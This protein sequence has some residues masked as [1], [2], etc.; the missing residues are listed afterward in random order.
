MTS[1]SDF[2]LDE[3]GKG[4]CDLLYDKL[5]A[6]IGTDASVQG[7]HFAVWAPSARAISVVGDFN[8]WRAGVNPL[9]SRG[10]SGVWSGFV[11]GV[12]Q[13][14]LYK[15]S[16]LPGD[17]RSRFDKADPLAFA[18]E[19]AP[20][21]AS[22]VWDV[23]GHD[24]GD[25]EW[26]AQRALR[27]SLSGPIAI[28]EVH[29]GSWMRVPEQGNRPLSYR[30]LAPKLADYV[31]EQGFTHVELLPLLEH[32]SPK[33]WGY[34][35]V[36]YFAPTSRLG[37]P[38]DLMFLIDTLHQ[39]GIG[40]ILDWVPAH[41]APDLH[42]LCEFD[43]THLYEPA[44]ALRRKFAIWNTYAFDYEKPPVANFLISSALFWLDKYHFDGLRV[45]GIEAMI[46]LAFSREAGKWRPN[47]LGGDENLEA[48]AFLERFNR[49][50]H[51]RFPGTLTFA[52]DATPRPNVTRPV[53]KGGLGFDQ[54]WDMGWTFDTVNHY[55]VLDEPRRRESYSKLTFRMHYAF[56]ESY[57]LPLSH[58]EVVPGKRSL[59]ARMPG[60]DW[61]KRANL[62]LLYGY[63]YTLPGKKLMFMGDEI[64][65]W[66]EWSHTTSIDWHLLS[67]SR[68]IGIQ[69]WVR[70]LNT[71]YRAEPAL[72]ELDCRADGFAWVEASNA[73]QSLLA[74]LRRGTGA[75]ASALVICNFTP[76]VYHN[77][78]VGVP[79]RGRWDEVLN[80]DA[81]IYG[82]SGQGNMGSVTTAPIGSH[83]QSQSLTLT[84]PPLA[85]LILKPS[86]S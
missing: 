51:E 79:E 45:D 62:R 14:A 32:P 35:V 10:R 2:D 26:M 29:L 44:D 4:A 84:V 15:Y 46:R 19:L 72:H 64:G 75:G 76:S 36:G 58:D 56:N 41:F 18:T 49:M 39:R 9:S 83:G 40:V 34:Q 31:H 47:K 7:T 24:W 55:M 54:K 1:L 6:H 65:Q 37:M 11:R 61:K 78:R 28:Y 69:R 60:D 71:F 12:G 59:L 16:I 33:S 17:G 74:F 77:I 68:H 30:E 50:V 53:E 22:K 66:Q 85:V 86:G 21:T 25:G 52:E 82:G 42:G 67:D 23:S 43:G 63:M 5:G 73:G 20:A 80:S 81:Q 27:Q 38:Q 3:I 8:G 70:D 13:G 57:L 48:I